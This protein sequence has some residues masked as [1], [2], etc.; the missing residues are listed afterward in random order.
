MQPGVNLYD[1]YFDLVDF[2][3]PPVIYH[4][5]SLITCLGAMLGRQAW[6]NFGSFR[7]FPNQYVMLI[8][9]PGARKS[10]AIKLAKK[11]LAESGFEHFAAERTSKEKFLMDLEA[12]TH[13]GSDEDQVDNSKVM[14]NLFGKDIKSEPREAFIVADEFNDFMN[15]GDLQFHS[16]LGAL[17]DWDDENV[18]YK[19]RLKNSKSIAIYQ[20]TISLLAGNTHTGFTEMF[21]PQ[22]IGQGFLS[23]MLLVFSEPSGKKIA[24]PEPPDRKK[25]EAFIKDLQTIKTEFK[26][27]IELTRKAKEVLQVLYNTYQGFADVRFTSYFTRRYTHLLKLSLL[28]AAAKGVDK[29][30]VE[31]VLLAN[32]ILTYTEHFMP[33]AL[34]EFGKARNADVANK[35]LTFLEKSNGPVIFKD[36]WAQV[37][38]DLDRTEDL[39]KLMAGLATANKVQW[40]KT[41]NKEGGYMI[42]RK[43]LGNKALYTDFNLLKEYR[44]NGLG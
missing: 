40:V 18:E 4:R 43:Q 1:Q 10:T 24:F 22:A 36:L 44:Q 25:K 5:W 7:I 23:R 15:C 21:P 31:Q 35:I 8:G 41:A 2:T 12:G 29:I 37:S 19:Q 11:F 13:D 28:C 3:E 27:E 38:S 30:D 26:G 9:D 33:K 32:T 42:V 14:E 6:I 16:M 39:D 17:W 20:P 34:G